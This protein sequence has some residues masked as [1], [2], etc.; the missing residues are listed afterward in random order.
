MKREY[1]HQGLVL[2]QDDHDGR[3]R[4]HGARKPLPDETADQ[5]PRMTDPVRKDLWVSPDGEEFEL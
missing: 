4:S 2:I 5:F 3:W 1:W